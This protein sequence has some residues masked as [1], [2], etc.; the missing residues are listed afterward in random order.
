MD[1][2]DDCIDDAGLA[3]WRDG[4][5]LRIY[6]D[7]QVQPSRS[8]ADV[9]VTLPHAYVYTLDIVTED[10]S[11][12][13]DYQNRGNV[14]IRDLPGSAT[15]RLGAGQAWISLADEL[16]EV[17]TCSD[18]DV[19]ACRDAAWETTA[20]PCLAAQLP[21]GT[22]TVDSGAGSPADITLDAPA[23][24]WTRLLLRNEQAGLSS[25]NPLCSS[26][27]DTD[28]A[29]VFV[30][31]GVDPTQTPWVFRGGFNQPPAPPA[32]LAGGYTA[33]LRSARCEGVA[34]TEQPEDFVGQGQGAMQPITV[35]GQ[36]SVCTDCL[37]GVPCEDL[38]PGS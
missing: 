33:T 29:V 32:V 19:Q 3:P 13:P 12:D 17:P 6:Y 37:D 10:D 5:Q 31:D 9:R 20:G 23:D 30:D 25:E 4:C 7:G 14:C 26:E 18:V 2:A 35:R 15:V 34:A 28:D 1:P 36:L 38:L 8:G 27:V 11:V 22:L 16:R 21:F 24:R